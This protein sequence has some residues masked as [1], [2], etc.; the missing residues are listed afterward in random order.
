MHLTLLTQPTQLDELTRTTYTWGV[1]YL[2]LFQGFVKD[3]HE[4]PD[5]P[6]NPGR[7]PS[8]MQLPKVLRHPLHLGMHCFVQSLQTSMCRWGLPQV[9]GADDVHAGF[10]LRDLADYS[11]LSVESHRGSTHCYCCRLL[12]IQVMKMYLANTRAPEGTVLQLKEHV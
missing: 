6:Q 11:R 5:D 12:R 7:V 9:I 3:R 8:L 4:V 2:D 1:V 10:G